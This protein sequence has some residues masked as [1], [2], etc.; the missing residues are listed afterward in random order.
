[1]TRK[2]ARG[3]FDEKDEERRRLAEAP[4]IPPPAEAEGAQA[5]AAVPASAAVTQAPPGRRQESMVRLKERRSSSGPAAQV[6]EVVA[7]LTNDPRHES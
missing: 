3:T 4:T 6:D 2:H 5:E 1:M 7:D